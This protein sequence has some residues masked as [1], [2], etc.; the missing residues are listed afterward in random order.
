MHPLFSRLRE[1]SASEIEAG[2][3]THGELVPETS[4]YKNTYTMVRYF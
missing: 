2:S 3:N 4:F 1:A